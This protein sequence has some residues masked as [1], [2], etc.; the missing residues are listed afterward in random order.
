MRDEY[1][2]SQPRTDRSPEGHRREDRF[3]EEHRHTQEVEAEVITPTTK[4]DPKK[5]VPPVFH[6]FLNEQP[7]EAIVIHCYDPLFQDAF[8]N[9]LSA[10][11]KLKNWTPIVIGGSIHSLGVEQLMPKNAKVLWEHIKFLVKEGKLKRII[12]INHDGCRWYGK[13]QGFIGNI[14]L[15]ERLKKDLEGVAIRLA[16]DFTGVQVETYHARV[17]GK[18]VFFDKIT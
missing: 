7:S 17:Q 18:E 2:R 9:F 6:Y 4:L 1:S 14:P 15:P 16:K 3:P 12:I 10:E 11:L 13:F 8:H 5:E